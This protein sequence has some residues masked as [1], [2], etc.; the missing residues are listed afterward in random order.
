MTVNN[1]SNNFI[2]KIMGE[3]NAR[4]MG[5]LSF[6]NTGYPDVEEIY[7][8]SL[9]ATQIGIYTSGEPAYVTTYVD[10]S[11]E[12]VASELNNSPF[13]IVVRS[14]ANIQFLKSGELLASGAIIPNEFNYLD[15]GSDGKSVIIRSQRWALRLNDTAAI[16]VKSPYPDGPVLPWWPRIS[17]GKFSKRL[18]GINYVFGVPEYKNQSWSQ[19]SG[20][21][22]RDVE[23][24]VVSFIGTRKIKTSRAP[25][26]KKG[27]NIVITN[28]DGSRV[29]S[30]SIIRDI[31][32][33]NGIIYLHEGISIPRNS[34]IYYTY[35]EKHYLYKNLNV[36]AHLT[37]NPALIDRYAVF[38]ALPITSNS[39]IE[40]ERGIYHSLGNSIPEAINNISNLSM[41]EP[42]AILGAMHISPA[43]DISQANIVDT[44]SFGG[45]LR[46]DKFGEFAQQKFPITQYFNDLSTYDGIPYH[47]SA[48]VAIELPNEI[49]SV[50]TLDEIKKATSKFI[51][52]GVYTILD[53][54]DGAD[55]WQQ[56]S[57]N[58][59]ISLV[60]SIRTRE[61]VPRRNI[62]NFSNS[63][64]GTGVAGEEGVGTPWEYSTDTNAY[65]NEGLS[66]EYVA[67]TGP[68]GEPN[69]WS[70][71]LADNTTGFS[72][73]TRRDANIYGSG[74]T[75]YYEGNLGIF[76][77][78][79]IYSV[80]VKE[81]TSE[82]FG[83]Y[84]VD[85]ETDT[86]YGSVFQWQSNIPVPI[87]NTEEAFVEYIRDG[88]WEC[89]YKLNLTNKNV[90]RNYPKGHKNIRFKP[91]ASGSPGQV[92]S[93][94][95]TSGIYVANMQSWNT[96]EKQRRQVIPY[97]YDSNTLD[98]SELSYKSLKDSHFGLSTDT[99]G[100]INSDQELPEYITGDTNAF[101][102]KESPT[103][104]INKEI[105]LPADN[106]YYIKYLK[107]PAHSRMFYEVL[108]SEGGWKKKSHVDRRSIPKNTLA[109]G[110]LVFSNRSNEKIREI[111]SFSAVI[112]RDVDTFVD[113]VAKELSQVIVDLES[114]SFVSTNN[115]GMF[116]QDYVLDISNGTTGSL[117]GA[118]SPN[119]S[120]PITQPLYRELLVNYNY[121]ANAGLYSI[122]DTP[123]NL[124]Q[125][126][127]RHFY[128]A[129]SW[130]ATKGF[131]AAFRVTNDTFAGFNPITD[132]FMDELYIYS[133]FT[134][135]RMDE[136]FNISGEAS[137]V[138]NT[139]IAMSRSGAFILAKEFEKSTAATAGIEIGSNI[140]G[141]VWNSSPAES[142][143]YGGYSEMASDISNQYLGT[144]Y[145]KSYA[146]LY[147][148]QD[149][150]TNSQITG[151]A[152]IQF[153]FNPMKIAA[154][155][156]A[157][158][159]H[160]F[161]RYLS[162]ETYSG[163]ARS[164]NW[165]HTY[166]RL[167]DLAGR[168]LNNISSA[169]DDIYYGN[170]EWAGWSGAND[171]NHKLGPLAQDAFWLGLGTGSSFKI[172][173]SFEDPFTWPDNTTKTLSEH[174][175]TMISGYKAATDLVR[176][177]VEALI[178]KGGV[179]TPGMAK[180]MKSFLW[181]PTHYA[182]N[183][184]IFSG[185]YDPKDVRIFEEGMGALIKG[186]FSE[187]GNC[188]EATSFKQESIGT[189]Y[190]AS[191]IL[192]YAL[193]GVEYH[194][195]LKDTDNKNKWIAIVQ[196]IWD[197]TTGLYKDTY[198]YPTQI[199]QN[200][201]S[202]D[203]GTRLISSMCRM[204]GLKTGEYS[205]EEL[206][207]ITGAATGRL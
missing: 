198:G 195:I 70:L 169:F 91:V 114:L 108:D 116:Q 147:S 51:A 36:N 83:I 62:L 52:K 84:F 193:D 20:Y 156:I 9:S 38:Y 76:Y 123:N 111:K 158:S 90:I 204:L 135:N 164:G 3:Q 6:T 125:E 185:F 93:D 34:V 154:S 19:V 37:Q 39:G 148:T 50:M 86:E 138:N 120:T 144:E 109:A 165:L 178:N 205:S 99:L 110:K 171:G 184:L 107:G 87:T 167:D 12:Q 24:E 61:L 18:N 168:F 29:F 112:P 177:R 53:F 161:E 42:L 155:G 68:N 181:I 65:R 145:I 17:V 63:F 166:N 96:E 28:A 175:P 94:F 22:F 40:R 122:E 113:E 35:L 49:T 137:V 124:I 142:G 174:I 77:D 33:I 119:I 201:T 98:L 101:D 159:L 64:K 46:D 160:H 136:Y 121:L 151:A 54:I 48:A 13:P 31:D 146:A 203:S 8:V 66:G 92:P 78:Y 127:A 89:S 126:R 173:E 43:I 44:R 69:V 15:L 104:K 59:E 105:E 73:I 2:R 182:K 97:M 5:A 192:Y 150:P 130:N 30:S 197:T 100:F 196:G 58:A 134:K 157:H 163:E 172:D 102:F 194:D 71:S 26:Y 67:V 149:R 72:H 21:P 55:Y 183:E 41:E 207:L 202:G 56:V 143:L 179:M 133:K 95:Y 25:L 57:G 200:S 117:L 186:M 115:N 191:E 153:S 82:Y 140:R 11:T 199:I 139:G 80:E 75:S 27:N 190:I 176:P 16:Q 141:V 131:P 129:V 85:E 32:T 128:N 162:N 81:N 180:L 47:G 189:P 88:W 132:F 23:G 14:L 79:Q 188:V 152:S 103:Q 74:K 60:P 206:V 187:D 7:K 170:D 1:I 118:I 10:K 4:P 106:S 45:G